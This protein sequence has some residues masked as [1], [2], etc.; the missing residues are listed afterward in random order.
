MKLLNDK[1]RLET[2]SHIRATKNKIGVRSGK[3]RFN[4]RCQYNA[5][6]EAIN[7]KQKR[8]AM[9]VYFDEDYPVIHFVNVNK[10]G[11]FTDN[12]LGNWAQQYEYFLIKYI[13]DVDYFNIDNV[14]IKYRKELKKQ[15]S[16][17]TSLFSDVEF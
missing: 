17:F 10:K 1:A 15:L 7:K 16:F 11:K 9:C 5:V 14:F 13:D 3:C 2:I 12:T 4:Y 8:I 6:H